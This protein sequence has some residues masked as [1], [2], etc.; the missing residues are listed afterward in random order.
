MPGGRSLSWFEQAEKKIAA[1]EWEE[2]E[3]LWMSAMEADPTDV[4][5]FM[6]VAHALR[7][8]GERPRADALLDLLGDALKEKKSWPERLTV[9]RELGRLS[10]KPSSFREALQEALH[11]TYADRPSYRKVLTAVG[12]DDPKSNPVEKAEKVQTWLQY[13]VGEHFFMS[14]RGPGV[15]TELNAELGVCRLDFHREKK[16]SVPLGAAPKYLEAIGEGHVLRQQFTSPEEFGKRVLKEPAQILGELLRSF[17]RPLSAGD[18]KDAMSGIVPDSRWSSWWTAARRNSQVV[19]R[20]AGAKAT[21]HWNDS[22]E[23]ADEAIRES[24]DGA[25]KLAAKVD[26]ARKH[27]GRNQELADFMS[28]RLAAAAEKAAVT[29]PALAWETF[30]VLEKL[31]GRF[32]S[33]FD[34]DQLLSGPAAASVAMH[35]SDRQLRVQ[36]LQKIQKRHP[37]WTKVFSEVFFKEED[38][39]VI[40]TIIEM[41]DENGASDVT[42]RLVD[43][44]VRYPMRHPFAFYWYCKSLDDDGKLPDKGG[45]RMFYQL[46][47]AIASD[48]FAPLRARLKD[49]FDKGGL[50]MRIVMEIDNEEEALKLM[51]NVERYGQLEDYRRELLKSALLYKYPRLREPEVEPVYAT[52]AAFAAKKA[53][54]EHLVKVEIPTNSKAIQVAREMGDLRENFEYK[55]ARQRAEYLAAR[56][57]EIQ[58]EFSRVRVLNPGEVDTSEVRIGTKATLRNGDLVRDVT[59]LGPWES[60]PETG[61]YSNLS[62]VAKALLG[63][64]VGDIV[65]FMGNDYQIEAIATWE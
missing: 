48:E 10:K 41:L 52:A 26:L 50:A 63:H 29:S 40:T 27:S 44:T 56:V 23:D 59:I 42:T 62:D 24:F 1:K 32:E 18:V 11:H 13:D 5:R 65:S 55:A 9:L 3:E 36:A 49:F 57:G 38:P 4:P 6:S 12:F 43:E 30:A 33:S 15:V 17:G 20:G 47:D 2:V 34:R 45:Y 31:P 58:G 8:A 14:A 37:D 7:K 54:L 22:T 46:L 64:K 16:V 39:R 35:V 25:K 28:R 53:E 61:V 51:Q 21:Y 60:S 19:V